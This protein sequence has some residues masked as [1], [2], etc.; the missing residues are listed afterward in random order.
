MTHSRIAIIL[1]IIC[2]SACVEQRAHIDRGDIV[3]SVYDRHLYQQDLSSLITD[4]LSSQDS[5]VTVESYIDKWTRDQVV[6]V[7]AE[8]YVADDINIDRLVDDYRS[9]LLSYTYEKRLVEDKLDTV[10]TEEDY[11]KVYATHA[12]QMPLNEPVLTYEYFSI[13]A[14]ARGIDRFLSDWRNGRKERVNKFLAKNAIKYEVDTN[15]YITASALQALL[16]P[17]FKDKRLKTDAR[18]IVNHNKAEHFV[19]IINYVDRGERPPL[20]YI[21]E[22]LRKRILND[23]KIALMRAVRDNLYHIALDNNKIKR[24]S[25]TT[26][27]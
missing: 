17:G 23:R 1:S 8:R 24:H 11:D 10:I 25:L 26:Q 6:I 4:E 14:K 20:P 16:P 27:Q 7:E 19:H 13:P 15:N 2:A 22:T 21:K 18:H 3:A 5:I 12:D 9:S